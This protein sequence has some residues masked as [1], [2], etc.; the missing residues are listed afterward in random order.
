MKT[1][2]QLFFAIIFLAAVGYGVVNY[3]PQGKAYFATQTQDKIYSNEIFSF[4]FNYPSDL[5]YSPNELEPDQ[6]GAISIFYKD[7]TNVMTIYKSSSDEYTRDIEPIEAKYGV[8]NFPKNGGVIKKVVLED[9][10]SI[11]LHFEH[12]NNIIAVDIKTVENKFGYD[13][14]VK[15][16]EKILNSLRLF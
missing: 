16:S 13:E 6:I 8:V 5:T 4:A 1:V 9:G 7:G 15:L 3:L 2:G 10:K 12:K 14:V 11:L